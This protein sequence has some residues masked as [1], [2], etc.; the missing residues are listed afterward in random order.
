MMDGV[1]QAAVEGHAER[2]IL[3]KSMRQASGRTRACSPRQLPTED[4]YDGA[5]HEGR[6]ANIRVINRRDSHFGRRLL[7]PELNP[8][9]GVARRN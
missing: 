8:E 4:D 3:A 5:P 7:H 6:S 2:R 9:G 1:K